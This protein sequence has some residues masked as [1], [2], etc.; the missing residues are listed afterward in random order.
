[1]IP[2][3]AATPTDKS[4]HFLQAIDQS[5]MSNGRSL[6][7]ATANSV[8]KVSK[9]VI[10]SLF[11]VPVILMSGVGAILPARSHTRPVGRDANAS[12]HAAAALCTMMGG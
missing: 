5:P 12:V 10:S 4:V 9:G 3:A 8:K 1:M 6:R 7:T 11:K 2:I